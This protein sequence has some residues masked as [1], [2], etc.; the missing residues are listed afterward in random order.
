M[1]AAGRESK[2]TMAAVFGLPKEQI[3]D[4]L[5]G[6]SE[7]I[8]VIANHNS[9][10]QTVISGAIA[11]IEAAAERLLAAGAKKVIRLQVSGAFHSSFMQGA[12][13]KLARE[14]EKINISAPKFPVICNVTGKPVLTG[15]EIKQSLIQQV[16]ASVLWEDSMKC[17]L[18]KNVTTFFEFGPGKVLKGLMRRIDNN[19]QVINIEKKEDILLLQ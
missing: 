19:A 12:S 7:G 3:Q 15:Q 4:V 2:G 6:I 13:L 16:S 9:P 1:A 14:L 10:D 18:S 8:V 17:I 5:S 11:A